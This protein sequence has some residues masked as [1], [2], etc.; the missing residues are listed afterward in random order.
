MPIVEQPL[1]RIAIDLTDTTS[2]KDGHRYI[3][4]I[5]DHFSCFVK[6]YPLKT[7]QASGIVSRLTQ[8]VAD[9]GAPSSLMCD[10]ALEFTGQEM[11]TWAQQHGVEMLYT[12]PYHP[13]ANGLIE[14]MHR[15]LKTVMAQLCKGYPLRWPSLLAK[16]QQLLNYAVHSSM[17]VTP[18]EAFFACQP[19]CVITSRLLSVPAEADKVKR[20]KI[21]IRDASVVVP[22]HCK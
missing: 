7:K 14:R 19:P 22:S 15:T 11:R 16:C 3:L 13:Q 2:G 21:I 9:F 20:L 8:Y 5:I 12:T 6:F 4:T 10:N 18:Y 1:Q 17:G